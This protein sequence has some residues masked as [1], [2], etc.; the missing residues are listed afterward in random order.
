MLRDGGMALVDT[1]TIVPVT[2]S[3]GLQEGIAKRQEELLKQ[4]YGEHLKFVD[5]T[6]VATEVGNMRTA[7]MVIAGA[8]STLLSFEV[9]T[10]H[11]AM[12]TVYRK[13][14][15]HQHSGFDAQSCWLLTGIMQDL[16]KSGTEKIG[17][18]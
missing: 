15:C 18:A 7:N 2:V 12:K 8:L 6:S 17:R 5:S 14:S 1:R 4:I 3:S 10:W 13:N 9:D 16:R 11:E